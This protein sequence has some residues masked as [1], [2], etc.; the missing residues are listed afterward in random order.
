MYVIIFKCWVIIV[1]YDLLKNKTNHKN[2][3]NNLKKNV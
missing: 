1:T 2:H 3:K